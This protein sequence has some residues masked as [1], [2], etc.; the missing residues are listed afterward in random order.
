MVVASLRAAE[1]A[2]SF[3]VVTREL[4]GVVKALPEGAANPRGRAEAADSA[5]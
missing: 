2:E 4:L 3:A 5:G 1:K